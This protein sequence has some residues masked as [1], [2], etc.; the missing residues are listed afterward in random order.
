MDQIKYL[1]VN[2]END[3]KPY[4]YKTNIDSIKKGSFVVVETSKGIE[5]GKVVKEPKESQVDT[6]S[7]IPLVI[8]IANKDD[9]DQYKKNKKDANNAKIIAQEEADKLK[10][11]MNFIACEYTLDRSKISLIYL[12]D[13]RVDFRELLK[14]LASIFHCRIELRQ[15]GPRDKAKTISGIGVCGRELCCASFLNDF[16]RIT[17]NMAKNQ[18]LAINMQK[19]SGHCGNLLC[20]LKYEDD[21]YTELRKEM[22]KLNSQVEFEGEKYQVASINVIAGNCKLTNEQTAIFVP[23]KEL[24]TKGKYKKVV[25]NT[26]NENE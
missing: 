1:V 19:L 11:N 8:R 9:Y 14:V 20:C 12:A 5:V 24:T 25:A 23:I 10:L 18:F 21:E 15:I 4:E 7:D 17:V 13:S 2:F 6:D 26:K 22:P 16:D 3:N